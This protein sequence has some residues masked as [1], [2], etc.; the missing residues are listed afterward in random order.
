M[1]ITDETFLAF[2]KSSHFHNTFPKETPNFKFLP[3]LDTMPSD[4]LPLP[5]ALLFIR[6][7]VS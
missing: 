4:E 2:P 5:N 1:K 6:V 7:T 3:I